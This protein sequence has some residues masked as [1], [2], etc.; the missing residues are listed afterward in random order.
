VQIQ[1]VEGDLLDQPV[2]V[3]VN[4][5]NRNVLPWWLLLPQG[6]SGAILRWAGSTPFRELARQEPLALGHATSTT[7]GRLHFK[8]IIHVASINLLWGSSPESIQHS[9]RSALRLAEEA[10]YQSIAFPLLGAGTGGF[11]AEEAQ[12]LILAGA[13]RSAFSGTVTVVRFASAA[14]P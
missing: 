12:E 13:S 14:P 8:A 4:P 6:V 7:A 11:K 2:D 9:V 5:W 3:I 10:G 1:V